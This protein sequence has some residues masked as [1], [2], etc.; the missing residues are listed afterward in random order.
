MEGMRIARQI[1]V[2]DAADLDAESSFWA[3]LLG[4][5][6]DAEDD[7]HMISVDGQP[8]LGIQLAPDH[9]PPDWPD[10]T[11]QQM[12]LDLYVDDIRVAHDE[13]LSLGA[14]L[15]KPAD[16]LDASE[17]FQVYADPAGHPFCLCWV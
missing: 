13:A 4:G 7:W 6:V 9:V 10:G 14:K 12:H 8:Q 16:D 5:T 1:V 11:P 3:A 15:L 17:G 2:L